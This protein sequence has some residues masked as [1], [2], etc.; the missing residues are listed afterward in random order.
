MRLIFLILNLAAFNAHA[1]SP[2][3]SNLSILTGKK[4]LTYYKIGSDIARVINEECG[5]VLEVRESLGSLDN[6]QRLRDEPSVQLAI[7]Q[8]DSIEYLKKVATKDKKI[9]R[10]VEA[11]RYVFPLYPEEVHLVSTRESSIQTLGDLEGKRVGVGNLESGTYLTSTFLLTAAGIAV[12]PVEIDGRDALERLSLH[13]DS[14]QK[15]DAF[16]LVTGKPTPLLAAEQ[17]NS[18]DLKILP[19]THPTLNNLKPYKRAEITKE[20]YSWVESP[21]ATL[22]VQAVLIAFNF[23]KEHCLNVGMIANRLKAN[24]EDLQRTAGGSSHSKWS[25]VDINSSL[26]SMDQYNCVAQYLSYPVIKNNIGQCMFKKVG[27]NP[28][29]APLDCSKQTDNPITQHLCEN[30]RK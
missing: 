1:Q 11:V 22:S 25:I 17:K 12:I 13:Q 8:E 28:S 19:I 14:A 7:V 29:I 2:E 24:I 10:L 20:D 23:Q 5:S 6:F 26:S 30:L 27:T 4:E 16:F 18:V 3:M 21:V 15:I 9:S